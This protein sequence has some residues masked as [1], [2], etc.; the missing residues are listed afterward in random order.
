MQELN[1][2][3]C[4]AF[5]AGA[6]ARIPALALE[7]HKG[8][9]KIL[10]YINGCLHSISQPH[11]SACNGNRPKSETH[12]ILECEI[13]TDIR[14]WLL[15]LLVILL[16]LQ[17]A[18]TFECLWALEWEF[19]D[20]N[21]QLTNSVFIHYKP[22]G[23]G[24]LSTQRSIGEF[25]FIILKFVSFQWFASCSAGRYCSAPLGLALEASLCMTRDATS[26][27]RLR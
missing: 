16:S 5:F 20:R 6:H 17:L 22:W 25:F 3:Q 10:V 2:D 23:W 24:H 1:L 18:P 27:K 11:P 13:T 14:Q 12:A 7:H 8:S 26:C 4:L 21:P 19:Q 9:A 15:T